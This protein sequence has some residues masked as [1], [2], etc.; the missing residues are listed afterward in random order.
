MKALQILVIGILLGLVP[1]V[2]AQNILDQK[3]FNRMITQDI[4]Y[5]I[6]GE[7]T[8]VTGIK[9]DISK[10][11]GTISAMFP[12]KWK[13]H[14]APD[15]F[16]FE[17]KGGVTDKSF[18]LLKGSGSAASA[19]EFKPSFHFFPAISSA[20]FGRPPGNIPAKSQAINKKN[21]LKDEKSRT[22]DTIY[23]MTLLYNHY[24][25]NIGVVK[26]L[27]K[28]Y[29][30]A[31]ADQQAIAAK[32][33]PTLINQ[34]ALNIPAVSSLPSIL[35]NLPQA[36]VDANNVLTS[37]TFNNDLINLFK[38]YEKRY[39]GIDIEYLDKQIASASEVWTQ[40]DYYWLTISP[41]VRSDKANEY[42][43]KFEGRDSLYFKSGF[44]WSYGISANVNGYWVW[45]KSIAVLLRATFTLME[46][47]NLSNLTPYNYETTTSFFQYGSAVTQKSKTGSAYNNSDIIEGTE[48]QISAELY[49][50]PLKSFIPGGYI[51]TSLS[52]SRLYNL[53]TI[54][55]REQDDFKFGF[56]GGLVFNI[57][58]R[59]KDKTYLSILP[60]FRYEDLTDKIRT[61]IKTKI[62]ESRKD[63]QDRNMSIGIK[64][65]IPITLPKKS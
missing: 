47:N 59:E 17:F 55:G 61:P 60:Y 44:R 10:P 18:S 49:I 53:P 40:K 51:S 41:I 13:G 54:I 62:E 57:N 28:N 25:K 43:T 27:P 65:G 3:A 14:L 64:V 42:Q 15:I 58:N 32:L 21:S 37:A 22:L 48:K 2:K 29:T 30:A 24:L 46:T 9:V 56:E 23:T 39:E 63:F 31:L 1:V 34:P 11:E 36:Q 52:S 38:K 8:P 5:A 6:T 35:A 4:T 19:F 20:F 45:P 16:S 12:L 50:L 33:I 7:S 26:P